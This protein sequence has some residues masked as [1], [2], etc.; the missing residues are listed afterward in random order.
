[1]RVAKVTEVKQ[2]N[3]DRNSSKGNQLKWFDGNVWYKADYLG[4]EALV[5]C[6]I[7]KLLEKTNVNDYVN[8]E[9]TMLDFC[10]KKYCG[11]KSHH[12]LKEGQELI[13]LE[14]LFRR[15]RNVELVREYAYMSTKERILYVVNGVKEITGLKNFG[16]YLTMLLELDALFLN[17]DRH[18]NNIA[19]IVNADGTFEYCPVFDNGAALFSDTM[20]S[21]GQDE[22]IEKCYEI[23]EAK[24]F[25]RMFDEQMDIAEEL[26]GYPLKCWFTIADIN[27]YLH[28]MEEY[29]PQKIL[30]RVETILRLQLRKYQYFQCKS[31]ETDALQKL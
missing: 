15:Y 1:M 8:Y 22:L 21:Y 9:I 7:S 27:H 20:I 11:C 31:S 24:P 17:E 18:T 10:G 30:E 16:S 28:E 6:L 4:Y 14:K 23:I 13:T 2:I 19:V 12:F 25:S 3:I 29:Y 26:Y 5:E